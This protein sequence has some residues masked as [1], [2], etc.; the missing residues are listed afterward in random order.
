MVGLRHESNGREGADSRT[1]NLAYLEPT[2]ATKLGGYDVSI[3]PRVWFYYGGQTGN[4]DIERYR[5][6]TGLSLAVGSDDG[7]RLSSFS[8]YNIGSG[9]GAAQIDASY[10]LNRLVWSRLNLYLYG[11]LFTGYGENLLDYDRQVTRARLGIA[12]VR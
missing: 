6:Y 9:K 3:G 10:P 5:G 4:E 11:Q 7:L 8:R 12:I 2:L 1:V